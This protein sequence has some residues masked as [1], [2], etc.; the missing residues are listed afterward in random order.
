RRFRSPNAH[1]TVATPESAQLLKRRIMFADVFES[2][3]G[4][5]RAAGRH[6]TFVKRAGA[7]AGD[8]AKEDQLFRVADRQRSQDYGVDECE[9]CR[10]CTDAERENYESDGGEGRPL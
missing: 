3:E 7:L 2:G 1:A 8:V 10:V 9:D 6:V 4:E 5:T